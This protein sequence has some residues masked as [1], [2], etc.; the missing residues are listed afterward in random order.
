MNA[1]RFVSIPVLVGIMSCTS[2]SSQTDPQFQDRLEKLGKAEI[3]GWLQVNGEALIYSSK[4]Q[5]KKDA[6]YPFCVSG[7]FEHHDPSRLE[8]FDGHKVTVTG[9]LYRFESLAQENSPVIPRRLLAGSVIPNFCNG[10]TVLL[11]DEMRPAQ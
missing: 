1:H 10:P 7:V 5:M 2:M 11:I 3:T 8:P 6:V 4:E 9:T